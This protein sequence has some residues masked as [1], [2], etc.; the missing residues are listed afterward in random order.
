VDLFEEK[1]L[2]QV[3]QTIHSLGRAS[4]KIQGYSGPTIGAKLAS[5]HETHFTEEQ[6]KRVMVLVV[7]VISAGTSRT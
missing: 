5:K 6:L 7:C 1:N 2:N 4:Q 3:V